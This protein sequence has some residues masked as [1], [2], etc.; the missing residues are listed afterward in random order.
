M[1]THK[2]ALYCI[3]SQVKDIITTL[4]NTSSDFN[5]TLKKPAS[6]D[7]PLPPA[8]FQRFLRSN[9][10]IP[11]VVLTDHSSVYTNKWVT[12]ISSLCSNV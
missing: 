3:A 5:L 10:K 9:R 8:S 4:S 7:Q 12:V 1:P 2:N 11:G 6:E